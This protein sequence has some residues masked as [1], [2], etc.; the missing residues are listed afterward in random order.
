MLLPLALAVFLNT[1]PSCSSS[2]SPDTVKRNLIRLDAKKVV[3]TESGKL[4]EVLK[5]AS[6]LE[7]TAQ[8]YFWTHNDDGIPALYCLDEKGM[9][10]RA[11]HV[12]GT[13]KGWEDLARDEEG[14]IYIGNFGNNKNNRK[15]LKIYKLPDPEKIE[16][17]PVIP[18]II[19]FHYPDQ[20]AFPPPPARQYYDADAFFAYQG[21]LF[22]FSKNRAVPFNGYTRVYRL[23]QQPGEQTAELIDSLYT[24][25]GPAINNWITGA[26]VSPDGKTVALLF[27]HRIWFIR[28]FSGSRFS[29]GKIYELVLNHYS[30]KTGIC[31]LNNQTLHL[32]DEVE[33]DLIGGKIYRLD[34]QPFARIFNESVKQ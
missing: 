29:S 5:E 2:P 4:P 25:N 32:V 34:L 12:N 13:N 10:K 18:E 7:I 15:D 8:G 22:I 28:N 11:L 19:R 16:K 6:G 21:N 33:F 17:T 23:T 27:H 1:G 14:N 20:K 24:G 26:D 3:L 31:F 30:H 9:L